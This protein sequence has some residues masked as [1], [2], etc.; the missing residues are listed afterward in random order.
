MRDFA[1]DSSAETIRIGVTVVVIDEVVAL[2]AIHFVS[3]AGTH[4][5]RK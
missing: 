2:A 5:R 1:E 4:E 3:A